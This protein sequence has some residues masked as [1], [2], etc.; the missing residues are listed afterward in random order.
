MVRF[1][2]ARRGGADRRELLAATLVALALTVVAE[3]VRVCVPLARK[4]GEDLGGT[5]GYLA[6]GGV[7]LL[8]FA[9]P[10]LAA[11]PR[12]VGPGRARLAVATGALVLARSAVQF[13]HP[14]PVWLAFAAVAVAL[15]GLVVI[16][17]S[18][19][20]ATGDR[21]L[22]LGVLVGLAF[23]TA[24]RGAFLTW[25]TA[26]QDEV[27]AVAVAVGVAVVAFAMAFAVPVSGDPE[28]QPPTLRLALFGPFLALQL[29][30]LQN[31]AAVA[32]QAELSLPVALAVVLVGD[33]VA[34]FALRIP[35]GSG[36]AGLGA[37]AAAA[38]G[39]G[40]TA[41]SG[42]AAAVLVVALQALLVRLLAR[43]LTPEPVRT[44]PGRP[45]RLAASI[46]VGSIGFVLAVLLFQIHHEAPLP[47]PNAVVPGVAAAMVGF[48]ASVRRGRVTGR[49][50]RT[51]VLVPLLL[52]LVPGVV[53]AT[54]PSLET[55]DGEG[56]PVRVLS[57]NVRGAVNVDGQVDPATTARLILE[58][59]P[60]VVVLQEV[61]RGWPIFGTQDVAEWLAWRLRM[62]FVYAPAADE[63]FGNAIFSRLPIL[64]TETG[65]LP[66][67]D[68]PQRRSY[69]RATID[70][71]GGETLVVVATHLQQ[72]EGS[73]T[74]AQQIDRVLEVWGGEAP[75]VIAGDMNLQPGE[76]DE[77]RFL[78]AG[79]VS[80][81]DEAGD[82]CEPTAW[83]PDPGEPCDRP[84]WIFTT[85]DLGLS[86]F[87][88]V[89]AP[90]S[91]HLP[92]AVTVTL[93]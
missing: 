73:D 13:V 26:W 7:A 2:R 72:T 86:D 71:G 88:I 21:A 84:D 81:Q 36:A 77:R 82:P 27:P 24:L 83:D 19:R 40:L 76:D 20:R 9:A 87:V 93:G 25:D 45:L 75:A 43:A 41:V 79:L 61:S 62:P 29:L 47:F 11:A 34:A 69:L 44:A 63:Q 30:F 10:L 5:T 1:R 39:Y 70:V 91:D 22:L 48:G 52:V 8:V 85:P 23:D 68:G 17:A 14:I 90:A 89:R 38:G 15:V 37:I 3:L 28:P 80:V 58:Q 55:I 35:L 67:G 32:A 18:I 59:E 46:A 31:P 6:A 51:V 50:P 54:R 92:L 57:F 65:P 33:V 56:R 60:D 78:G 74:R 4:L 42:P 16:A 53:W 49:L 12:V 64:R 66:F